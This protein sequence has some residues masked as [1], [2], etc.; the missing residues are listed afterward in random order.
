MKPLKEDSLSKDEHESHGGAIPKSLTSSSSLDPESLAESAP[1]SG[2]THNDDSGF[3]SCTIPTTDPGSFVTRIPV[4]LN[5]EQLL[6]G[7]TLCKGGSS[8]T[9]EALNLDSQCAVV[10]VNGMNFDPLTSGK[11]DDGGLPTTT[12]TENQ[13]VD[14]MTDTKIFFLQKMEIGHSTKQ[15]RS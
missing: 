3:Y 1:L 5:S 4:N 15:L 14:N 13:T 10:T 6:H 2:T 9:T 7:L 8:S 11:T 12:L